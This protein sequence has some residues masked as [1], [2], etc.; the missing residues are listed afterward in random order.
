MHPDGSAMEEICFPSPK[1]LDELT[2]RGGLEADEVDNCVDVEF[3][4]TPSKGARRILGS[5]SALTL[6]TCAQAGC[7]RYIGS[8]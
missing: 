1:R 8:S 3:A 2:G 4:N 5:R 6:R 7:C